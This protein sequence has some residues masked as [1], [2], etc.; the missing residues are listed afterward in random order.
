MSGLSSRVRI[1]HIAYVY[2][3]MANAFYSWEA[4]SPIKMIIWNKEPLMGFEMCLRAQS[5][6]YASLTAVY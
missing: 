6:L 4:V 5:H 1:A 3:V 2:I